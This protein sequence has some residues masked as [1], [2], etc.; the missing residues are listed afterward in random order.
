MPEGLS[1]QLVPKKEKSLSVIMLWCLVDLVFGIL[2]VRLPNIGLGMNVTS[3]I[4]RTS[5]MLRL[6]R[7][8]RRQ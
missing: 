7:V 8:R 4:I 6:N 2:N 5:R 1:F 3:P